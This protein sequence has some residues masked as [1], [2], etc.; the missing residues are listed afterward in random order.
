MFINLP[1]APLFQRGEQNHKPIAC[2]ECRRLL[3]PQPL[4]FKE[5]S[6]TTSLSRTG[7]AGDPGARQEQAALFRRAID[8][9][10]FHH[11]EEGQNVWMLTIRV[12]AE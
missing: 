8:F 5:G 6:R 12:L 7:S 9:N 1:P 11:E 2:R 10:L 4:F 3:L